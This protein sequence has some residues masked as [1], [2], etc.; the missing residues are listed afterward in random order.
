MFLDRVHESRVNRIRCR[1]L[2]R[3]RV[4]RLGIFPVLCPPKLIADNI[5]HVESKH[6]PQMVKIF[7]GGQVIATQGMLH[8]DESTKGHS[9]ALTSQCSQWNMT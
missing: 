4:P 9:Q 6:L 2:F 8:R 3:S 1:R 7:R 5:I